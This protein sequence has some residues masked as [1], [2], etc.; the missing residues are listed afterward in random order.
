MTEYKTGVMSTLYLLTQYISG[1][2][3]L[4]FAN[5]SL[6]LFLK[7]LLSKHFDV[8]LIA[9]LCAVNIGVLNLKA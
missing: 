1:G 7:F 9:D 6:V 8:V 3:R 2:R 5:L 4:V